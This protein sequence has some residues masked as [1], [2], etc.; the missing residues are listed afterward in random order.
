MICVAAVMATIVGRNRRRS[1]E[2]FDYIQSASRT[3]HRMPGRYHAR[4]KS[5]PPKTLVHEVTSNE[6]G[7]RVF[8]VH[9]EERLAFERTQ[10]VK[11]MNRVRT[12]LEKTGAACSAQRQARKAAEKIGAGRCQDP[13]SQSWTPL[14]RLVLCRRQSFASSKHPVHFTR[15]QAV[16]RQIRHPVP[17]KPN[18]S[19]VDA[20]RLYKELSEVE[21]A[22]ARRPRQDRSII[23][24]DRVQD[25]AALAFL[26]H[27]AIES[28]R[29]PDLSAK[30]SPSTCERSRCA[31][32]SRLLGIRPT[33]IRRPPQPGQTIVSRG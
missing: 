27:R 23:A 3:L 12:R 5:P 22:F 9:S 1:G 21:R 33:S 2:V 13:R 17:R 28:S 15:E 10:R 19:A 7:V 16:R 31:P 11:S 30:A 8:V 24:P 32:G 20:V 14:L 26:L 25:L 18:L 29:T 4:E 6:P